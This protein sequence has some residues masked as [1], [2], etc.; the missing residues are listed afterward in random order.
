MGE[1]STICGDIQA[2]RPDRPSTRA[3]SGAMSSGFAHS[4]PEKIRRLNFRG[5]YENQVQSEGQPNYRDYIDRA[6]GYIE[7]RL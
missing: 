3:A 6:H 2:P 5:D 4:D 7:P 1:N